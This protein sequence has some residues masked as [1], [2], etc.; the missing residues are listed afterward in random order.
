MAEGF[1]DYSEDEKA[2][3][4]V[5]HDC[6]AELLSRSLIQQSNDDAL[7]ENFVL[8]DLV[9]DLATYISGKSCCRLE[10]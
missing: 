4:E 1:L 10:H 7:G 8:H 9:N 5:G 3:E 2:V 6:F